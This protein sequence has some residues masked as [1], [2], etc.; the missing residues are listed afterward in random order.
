MTLKLYLNKE[1]ADHQKP[2]DK[3]DGDHRFS[4]LVFSSDS[5]GALRRRLLFLPP[6]PSLALPV[7]LLFVVISVQLF[8]W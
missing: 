3:Q 6:A 8:C 2:A 1:T 5:S 7:F 4:W